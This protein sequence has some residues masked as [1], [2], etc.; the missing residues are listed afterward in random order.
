MKVKLKE[1]ILE[2]LEA[3]LWTKVGYAG[4]PA[5]PSSHL[6]CLL[7]PYQS[8]NIANAS[9][10]WGRRRS[11]PLRVRKT[12]QEADLHIAAALGDPRHMHGS[13]RE[14]IGLQPWWKKKDYVLLVADGHLPRQDG[15]S[16]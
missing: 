14:L 6:E 2:G 4:R 8:T 1:K 3:H 15:W 9:S 13:R 10:P 11:G 7:V 16:S 12:R 5:G